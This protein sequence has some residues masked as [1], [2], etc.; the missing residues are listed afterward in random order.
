MA[1][2]EF[3]TT[4]ATRSLGVEGRS[5]PV[6]FVPSTAA[7]A[8]CCRYFDV[9]SAVDLQVHE[10]SIAMIWDALMRAGAQPT[11]HQV[12]MLIDATTMSAEA[13]AQYGGDY[14]IHL[15]PGDPIPKKSDD[16]A[17]SDG[18]GEGEEVPS[19]PVV[20]GAAEAPTEMP[21]PPRRLANS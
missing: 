8:R 21:S 19:G 9:P 7:V 18:E 2:I 15:E 13:A 3:L 4:T 20:D 6:P 11:F 10:R 17:K 12:A 16:P 1:R 14:V 5:M